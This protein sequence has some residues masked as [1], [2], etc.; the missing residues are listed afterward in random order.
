[1]FL[2][3]AP[4]QISHAEPRKDTRH[5]RA[6]ACLWSL[7]GIL[8]ILGSTI[9][10]AAI[11]ETKADGPR[12]GSGV[13]GITAKGLEHFGVALIVVGVVGIL[14]ESKDWQHYFQRQ[15]AHTI[16]EKPFIHKLQPDDLKTLQTE[17]AKAFFKIDDL[18]QKNG[19]LGYFQ[20]Q[21]HGYLGT[22]FREDVDCLVCVEEQAG[23]NLFVSESV[24]YTCRKV[25]ERIQD[26][27]RWV[28]SEEE[29][30]YTQVSKFE[31]EIK[32]PDRIFEEPDFKVLHPNV[33]T[34]MQRFLP[35]VTTAAAAA[36]QG[37]N[38]AP[39]KQQ[40]LTKIDKPPR[41]G[42]EL[43]LSD[44]AGIDGLRVTVRV[45]YQMPRGYMNFW[46]MTHLSKNVRIVIK[47]PENQEIQVARFGLNQTGVRLVHEVGIY[48]C[49]YDSWILPDT[50]LAIVFLPKSPAATG[51]AT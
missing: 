8:L 25:G 18:D 43:S 30:H 5:T 17:T 10:V 34:S 1:M 12:K 37:E 11:E 49:S 40:K 24:S 14:V 44:Y 42:Y 41:H 35:V 16:L 23:P 27:V 48:Q 50:G 38:A 31:L 6:Y 26:H 46:T 45:K 47:F 7:T 29:D 4:K 15:I 32:V 39:L 3:Q 19:F 51:A 2:K 9:M 33:A 28:Y 20:D 13:W 22:P 36:A 21:L